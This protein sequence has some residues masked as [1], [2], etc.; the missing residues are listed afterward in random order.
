MSFYV[1]IF[2]IAAYGI[3]WYGIVM[4][5]SFLLSI[6]IGASYITKYKEKGGE[7]KENIIHF[8]G[9][10][11]FLTIVSVYFFTSAIPHGW[12]NLR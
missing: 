5:F 9:S 2:I 8:F 1:F 12:N 6:L 3:V 4:Y 7:S 10:I 11:V